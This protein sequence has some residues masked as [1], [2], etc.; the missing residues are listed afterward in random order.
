MLPL[1]VQ[2]RRDSTYALTN[3]IEAGVS[4]RVDPH[5]LLQQLMVLVARLPIKRGPLAHVGVHSLARHCDIGNIGMSS[6][7]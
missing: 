4:R 7:R 6:G 2:F 1:S 3:D 5:H